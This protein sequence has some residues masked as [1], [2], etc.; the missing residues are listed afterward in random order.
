MKLSVDLIPQFKHKAPEGYS[1]EV[2][3]FKRSV[4]SIWLRCDRRFDYNMG[5]PT[6]TIWG[7]YNYKKCEFYSP[8]N[9]STIGK[10]VDFKNTRNYTA[11]PI[12]QTVLESCFV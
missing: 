1:Y 4:F 6:R 11:M 8:V 3:E 2:E 12:K 5:K 10:Q 9:S 7:F